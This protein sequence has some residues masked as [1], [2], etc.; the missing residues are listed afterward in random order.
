K[1]GKRDPGVFAPFF[2]NLMEFAPGEAIFL[3]P[4]EP[5]SYLGG[6]I[7]ECMAAS[8]NVVRAGLTPKFC[9][10]ETLLAMLT[11]RTGLP[12]I[13]RP[14]KEGSGENYKVPVEDFK[15]E[16]LV[17][18]A[19]STGRPGIMIVLSGQVTLE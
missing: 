6:E 17:G 19:K 2:L 1:Y 10:V 15:L 5:H 8:D 4:N 9:D 3:G 14:V 16:K 18:E 12:S 11:Y 13:V 7:L